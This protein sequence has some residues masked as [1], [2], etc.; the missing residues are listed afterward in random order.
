MRKLS[1][2]EVKAMYD[3]PNS[4]VQNDIDGGQANCLRISKKPETSMKG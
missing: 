4:P 3:M 2:D 1:W